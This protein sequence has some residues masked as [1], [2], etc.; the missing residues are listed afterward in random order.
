MLSTVNSVGD[1]HQRNTFAGYSR[2]FW[3]AKIPKD[4][5][6]ELVWVNRLAFLIIKSLTH[7]TQTR[8]YNPDNDRSIAPVPRHKFLEQPTPDLH[9]LPT[10]WTPH[11]DIP[12]K[13]LSRSKEE[14]RHIISAPSLRCGQ[15]STLRQ[16][17]PFKGHYTPSLPP[18]WGTNE[19]L[20]P[21]ILKRKPKRFGHVNSSMTK[22]VRRRPNE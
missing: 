8:W 19:S 7:N 14:T 15:W 18:R 5:W 12:L 22:Y 13:A 17:L 4:R 3:S 1:P 16:M 2:H 11:P 6:I 9:T 20:P 21:S 10:H